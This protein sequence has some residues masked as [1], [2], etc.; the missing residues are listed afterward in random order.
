MEK[1]KLT[2]KKLI[3]IIVVAVPLLIV[4]VYWYYGEY[5]LR[6][7][8][9]AFVGEIIRAGFHM[10]QVASDISIIESDSLRREKVVFF[11]DRL[12]DLYGIAYFERGVNRRY[13]LTAISTRLESLQISEIHTG[14]GFRTIP[15]SLPLRL[16]FLLFGGVF[17]IFMIW[18]WPK[19]IEGLTNEGLE[20]EKN[21]Q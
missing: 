1:L 17:V 7:D 18:K 19:E 15:S 20:T 14:V 9:E 10:P 4:A 16:A 8:N 11:Y 6:H 2:R 3:A 13:R 21:E 12:E 5:S